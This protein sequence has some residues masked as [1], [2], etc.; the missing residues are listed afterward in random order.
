MIPFIILINSE[1]PGLIQDAIIYNKFIA[2]SQIVHINDISNNKIIIPEKYYLIL[3]ENLYLMDRK[4]N[5]K[6][7]IKA[8]RRYFMV[9]IDLFFPRHKLYS[10]INVFICKFKFTEQCIKKMIN[11][12]LI[13]SNVL[14]YFTKHTSIFSKEYNLY[15]PNIKKDFKLFLHSSGKSPFKN[16]ELII[17][18]WLNYNLPTIYITCYSMCLDLITTQLSNKY[19]LSIDNL[20]KHNIIFLK[21]TLDIDFIIELKNKCGIHLCPSMKEGYGH[22]INECR[23]VKSVCITINGEPFTE[24]INEK[25]GF[26]LPYNTKIEYHLNKHYDYTFKPIDLAKTVRQIINTPESDLKNMGKKSYK[27]YLSDLEY[28]QNKLKTIRKNT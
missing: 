24:L 9:N 27:H 16:T 7:F 28:L 12:N 10:F 6:V 26:L 11:E 2:N 15:N 18:T 25:T 3:L 1:S 20:K 17:E 14:T 22:Y 13:N 23:Q 4:D 5:F 21:D 8:K 19:D